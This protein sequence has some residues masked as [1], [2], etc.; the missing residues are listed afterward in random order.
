MVEDLGMDYVHIPVKN[1]TSITDSDAE[2]LH[3]AVSSAK[4]GVLLHCTVGWRASG[5]FAIERLLNHE[6]SPGEA[7]RLAVAAHMAHAADDVKKWI[8]NNDPE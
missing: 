5:R 3:E 8:G 6:V 2:A 4:G 7:Y 1:I